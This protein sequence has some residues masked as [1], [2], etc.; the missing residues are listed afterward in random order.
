MAIR[1]RG[2]DLLGHDKMSSTVMEVS[3][4]LSQANYDGSGGHG[5]DV[6][7]LIG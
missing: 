3:W 7:G 2:V 5:E 4:V 6:H 1:V